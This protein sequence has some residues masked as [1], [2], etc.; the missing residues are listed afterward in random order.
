MHTHLP[1]LLAEILPA[2]HPPLPPRLL[3]HAPPQ[4]Q[5]PLPFPPVYSAQPHRQRSAHV[6][7]RDRLDLHGLGI[8]LFL[9]DLV[10]PGFLAH[11]EI[12]LGRIFSRVL[13]LPG[14]ET[15]QRGV[16]VHHQDKYRFPV[17]GGCQET[18]V[19]GHERG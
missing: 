9:P 4:I 2:H 11:S 5:V 12:F 3:G 7:L 8:N 17:E 14:E 10:P 16:F 18:V 1:H 15:R 13:G 19:E 6:S